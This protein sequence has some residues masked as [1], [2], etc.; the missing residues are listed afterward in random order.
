MD[1]KVKRMK[2]SYP[3]TKKPRYAIIMLTMRAI[4]TSCVS[5]VG[6]HHR[7]IISKKI[8]IYKFFQSLVFNDWIFYGFKIVEVEEMNKNGT[9]KTSEV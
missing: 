1:I 3:V 6:R 5:K 9:S 2:K 4:I 7:I 8:S